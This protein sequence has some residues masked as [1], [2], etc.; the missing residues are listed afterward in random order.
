[1]IY[2]E[3]RSL[4]DGAI[5]G[6]NDTQLIYDYWMIVDQLVSGLRWTEEDSIEWINYNILGT[7]MEGWPLI[8]DQ[9]YED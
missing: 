9:G 1:M 3:P 8:I 6:K 5:I 4:Y 7:F 2:L